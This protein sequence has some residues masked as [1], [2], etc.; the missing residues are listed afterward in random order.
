MPRS[1]SRPSST[2]S[3]RRVGLPKSR[4]FSSAISDFIIEISLDFKKEWGLDGIVIAANGIGDYLVVIPDKF[5]EQILVLMHET[6]ELKLF[7][8]SIDDLLKNG[9]EDYF[10]SDDH[11]FKLDDDELIESETEENSENSA[12]QIELRNEDDKLRIYLDDLID[13]QRTEKSSELL[14]GLEKLIDG[15]DE[16]HKVWALNKLSDIYLKGFGP[17]PKNMTLALDYNQRAIDLN[18]HKALSNRA[19][20]YF[21]GFGVEKNIEK[22]LE[23][24]TRANELSKANRFADIL[25]AKEGGGMYDKLV[26]MIET[27]LKKQ[28]KVADKCE[29]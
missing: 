1:S 18:S 15:N 6:A 25:A 26:D 21:F 11:L 12:D 3:H 23:L 29:W 28:G 10:W 24:A 14:I 20:C 27:E 9:P 2:A 16:S 13:D 5:G 8:N 19:A 22:A 17:I 7:G 4:C